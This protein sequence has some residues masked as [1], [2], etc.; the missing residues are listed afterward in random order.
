[1]VA[2][3]NRWS[4]WG[5]ESHDVRG[6]GAGNK[7]DRPTDPWSDDRRLELQRGSSAEF[8]PTS[9]PRQIRSQVDPGESRSEVK[10]GKRR[11]RD[12]MER[13]FH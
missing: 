2:G 7:A 10:E 5:N 12:W 8:R 11:I 4:R 9:L 1:M 13:S 6:E 3:P